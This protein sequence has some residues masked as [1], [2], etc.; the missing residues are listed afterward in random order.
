MRTVSCSAA[1]V[2]AIYNE[3][4]GISSC[5]LDLAPCLFP[6]VLMTCVLLENADTV[7]SKQISKQDIT[8]NCEKCVVHLF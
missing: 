4:V 6:Y 2:I 5:L 7:T 8:N 1:D 3:D